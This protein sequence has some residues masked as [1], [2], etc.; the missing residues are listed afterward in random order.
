LI[1]AIHHPPYSLDSSKG[2]TRKVSTALDKAF[3]DAGRYPNMVLSGHSHNYQRFSRTVKAN[4][5]TSYQ[6]PYIVA[7]AGCYP[8]KRSY[9]LK[10]P[11]GWDI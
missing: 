9:M 3:T 4:G 6:T 7:G 10:M 1:V 2:C 11:A 8:A 5:Q